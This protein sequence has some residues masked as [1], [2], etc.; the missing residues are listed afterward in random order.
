MQRRRLGATSRRTFGL[1]LTMPTK[2]RSMSLMR[3]E[4][5]CFVMAVAFK[6]AV[7]GFAALQ[8]DKFAATQYFDLVTIRKTKVAD[9]KFLRLSL[10]RA[11]CWK[12]D[13]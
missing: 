7:D 10:R 12:S 5:L 11:K 9:P 6:Q 4:T 13:E 2:I 3:P 8:K 1:K